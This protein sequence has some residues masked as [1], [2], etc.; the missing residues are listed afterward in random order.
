MKLLNVQLHTGRS[1]YI[2]HWN[3]V[4]YPVNHDHQLIT[5]R[6]VT[7]LLEAGNEATRKDYPEALPYARNAKPEG[8]LEPASVDMLQNGEIPAGK[9]TEGYIHTSLVISPT[10][11]Q[12]FICGLWDLVRGHRCILP[13]VHGQRLAERVTGCIVLNICWR[14]V[15]LV[16]EAQSESKSLALSPTTKIPR[17]KE[18][19]TRKG[20]WLTADRAKGWGME[21]ASR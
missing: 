20:V 10:S 14:W 8:S 15:T 7:W 16:A 18:S 13:L 17:G 12:E 21:S 9:E 19:Q 1:P 5:H 6:S 2:H 11:N 3:A 4:T